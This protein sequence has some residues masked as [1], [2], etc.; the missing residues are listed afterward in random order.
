M[1]KHSEKTLLDLVRCLEPLEESL[2]LIGLGSV[3]KLTQVHDLPY[4]FT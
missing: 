2:A 3:N 1:S 4:A